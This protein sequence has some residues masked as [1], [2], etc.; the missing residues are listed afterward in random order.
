MAKFHLKPIGPL[1]TL[2]LAGALIWPAALLAQLDLDPA[3]HQFSEHGE[4]LDRFGT[5][6]FFYADS[7]DRMEI[8]SA[9]PDKAKYTEDD[10]VGY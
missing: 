8:R 7:A 3:R 6:F 2:F 10:I 4:L 5:P 1:W 9:G